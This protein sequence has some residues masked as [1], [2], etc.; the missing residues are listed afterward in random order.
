MFQRFPQFVEQP[1]VLDGDYGLR[2]EIRDE[3]DLLFV[4]WPNLCSIDRDDTDDRIR[5]EHRHAKIGSD[6]TDI[7]RINK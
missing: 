7:D 3:C 5:L 2:S 1:R 4:E 6:A